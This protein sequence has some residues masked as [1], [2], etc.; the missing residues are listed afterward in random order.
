MNTI[1]EVR[2]IKDVNGRILNDKLLIGFYQSGNLLFRTIT[3]HKLSGT[4]VL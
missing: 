1:A 2:K 3:S 4:I